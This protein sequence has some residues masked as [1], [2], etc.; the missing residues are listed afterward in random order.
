MAAERAR[1]FAAL[2]PSAVF[3]QT[4]AEV[5]TGQSSRDEVLLTLVTGWMSAIGPTT[6]S[7]LGNLLGLAALDIEK[8]LLRM[9]AERDCSCVA[10]SVALACGRSARAHG[11]IELRST[12]QAQPQPHETEWCERRLLAR[13]HRLTVGMLRKQIEPVTAAAFL[14]WLMR[15]Q[16]VTPGTQVVG[17]RG[18]MEVLE[19]LQ[20]FEIPAN[21]WER[22]VLARRIVDYDPQ[23]LDQLCLTGAVGWGR[24]S[25]HPATVDSGGTADGNAWIPADAATATRD[26]DQ[27]G[28]DYIFCTR[29][30]GLDEHPAS[31]A[32]GK[33][34]AG[35]FRKPGM[36]PRRAGGGLSH[37]AHLVLEFLR[38]RGGASFFARW[39]CARHGQTQG[40]K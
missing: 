13:I 15:W 25:P 27:R 39:H 17:E 20:G 38:Q 10:I 40:G 7:Q 6:A 18:T 28:A 3:E 34:R 26:S 12:G 36:K 24:L 14:R 37:G 33:L 35:F 8:A 31:H 1:S 22:Q 19:Q 16:H 11:A 4:L 29:G 23:W 2:F 32:A 30:S 9:E 5:E 21:A